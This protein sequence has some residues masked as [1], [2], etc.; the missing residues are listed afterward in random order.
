MIVSVI[1]GFRRDEAAQ[2]VDYFIV[3]DIRS[4]GREFHPGSQS[5]L[6]AVWVGVSIM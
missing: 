4:G 2:S 3:R 6:A 1:S 5:P